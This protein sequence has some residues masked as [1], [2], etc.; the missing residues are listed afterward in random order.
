MWFK[1]YPYLNDADFI[2]EI[3]TQHLQKQYIKI[4]LLDWEENPIQEIQ[5]I[6][7]GGSISVNSN[8]AV[9]RTCSLTMVV[10]GEEFAITSSK[11]L[12]SIGR[13]AFIEIGVSNNTLKY[14]DEYPIIWFPQGYFVFT[15]CSLSTSNSGTTLSAQLK[16]KMCLLNGECGGIITASTEFHKWETVDGEGNISIQYPTIATIIRDAVNHIGGEQLGKILISDIDEKVKLIMRWVGSSPVYKVGSGNNVKLVLQPEEGAAYTKFE[17][18]DSIGFTYTDFIYTQD[19]TA[20]PGDNLCT[21]V[22][23]KIKSYLGNFEYFYDVYGN[24]R[25]QEIKNYLNTTQAFVDSAAITKDD[26]KIDI[27]KGKSVYD[28]SDSKLITSFSN[29]PQY[30]HIKNDYVIW[31]SKKLFSGIKIP[32]RYHLAIDKKP[33]TGNIYEVVFVT[34]PLDSTIEIPKKPIEFETQDEWLASGNCYAGQVYYIINKNKFYQWTNGA[35]EELVGLQFEKIKTTDWRSELLFDGVLQESYGAAINPYYAELKA[36][37]LKIYNL[38]AEQDNNGVW[39]GAFIDNINEH[40]WN[41]TYWLDF[42][43]PDSA[44]GA[45]SIGNIGRR[46]LVE[47]KDDYTCVFEPEIM[48]EILIQNDQPDTWAKE[49]ECIARQQSFILVD[50]N[51]YEKLSAGVAENSCFNKVKDA[52]YDY[53]SYNSS[54]SIGILPIYHLEP[55]TRITINSKENDMFGDYLIQ[56][57]SIPLT[58]NGTMSISAIQCNA[59]L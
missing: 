54:I 4:T 43:E 10:K 26:Y 20:K 9:R 48:D 38:R 37:W 13:K 42:I 49:Q 55:N 12:I 11:N 51:I 36:E 3:D 7:T 58:I 27:S 17:Y 1:K 59:K 15:Q 33:K 39:T 2:K 24:F 6:A 14:K 23:D 45:L 25:F 19:L 8:S 52:L 18:G 32:I 40:P 47:Q 44:V 5:G 46:S 56:S 57:F 28:F 41:L 31:G 50:K 30:N 16:D 22:L 35:P 34:D 21:A 53:T 29:T